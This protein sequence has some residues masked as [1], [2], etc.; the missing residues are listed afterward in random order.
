M[1]EEKNGGKEGG[2]EIVATNF[3]ASQLPI[4]RPTA[5]PFACANNFTIGCNKAGTPR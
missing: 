2:M 1:M 5:P 3:A 4:R